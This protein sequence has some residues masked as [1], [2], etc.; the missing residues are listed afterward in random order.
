MEANL[1]SV[2]KPIFPGPHAG[3]NAAAGM[4]VFLPFPACRNALFAITI[5]QDE[6]S[7]EGFR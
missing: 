6:I 1:L 7:L 2:E 4:H 5:T 3:L